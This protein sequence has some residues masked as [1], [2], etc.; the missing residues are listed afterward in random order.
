[1]L[2]HVPDD[3]VV[4]PVPSREEQLT[5]LRQK[6][7]GNNVFG[8]LRGQLGLPITMTIKSMVKDKSATQA[9]AEWDSWS[10]T[11]RV[12]VHQLAQYERDGWTHAYEALERALQSSSY[13]F[14]GEKHDR[15]PCSCSILN[16]HS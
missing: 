16:G 15:L 9:C 6:L 13:V 7:L 1:M 10:A 4:V 2:T 5:H 8:K 3:G 12:M 11:V 14:P